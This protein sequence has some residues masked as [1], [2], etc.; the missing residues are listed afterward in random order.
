M[1]DFVFFFDL[2]K[3]KEGVPPNRKKKFP[4]SPYKTSEKRQSTAKKPTLGSIFSSTLVIL[5]N[6]LFTIFRNNTIIYQHTPR[7]S[8]LA[9]KIIAQNNSVVKIAIRRQ[10]A[11]SRA[12]QPAVDIHFFGHATQ[13]RIALDTNT[14]PCTQS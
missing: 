10:P 12:P 11:I 1:G 4:I 7:D 14:T 2:E 8:K 9:K 13:K 5:S 3:E 6:I